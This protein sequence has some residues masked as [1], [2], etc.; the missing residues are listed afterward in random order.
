M[1]CLFTFDVLVMKKSPPC[2]PCWIGAL[3]ELW[4]GL[5]NAASWKQAMWG[6]E[7]RGIKGM[8]SQVAYFFNN[9]SLPTVVI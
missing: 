8:T 2:T 6:L 7:T 3:K 5:H 9:L 4:V 1:M